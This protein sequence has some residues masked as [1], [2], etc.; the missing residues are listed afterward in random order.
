MKLLK[1]I[2]F[3]YIIKR[4]FPGGGP[5]KKVMEKALGATNQEL[6]KK[7]IPPLQN[8]YQVPLQ[9][10]EAIQTNNQV[11]PKPLKFPEQP[12]K[13]KPAEMQNLIPYKIENE[14][15]N[16][17]LDKIFKKDNIV[18]GY[19][20]NEI[21]NKLKNL[22]EEN[23]E[24][25]K[26][27]IKK[28]IEDAE[29]EILNK[30]AQNIRTFNSIKNSD[31][32]TKID[33]ENEAKKFTNSVTDT[34][35][36]QKFLDIL[37]KNN[38]LKK[39]L[40]LKSSEPNEITDEIKIAFEL[41]RETL[42]KLIDENLDDCKQKFYKENFQDN[43]FEQ[44]VLGYYHKDAQTRWQY[45]DNKKYLMAI[46]K[47]LQTDIQLN[48][49]QLLYIS[50]QLGKI[51]YANVIYKENTETGIVSYNYGENGEVTMA[52]SLL[53][54]KQESGNIDNE[55]FVEIQ[56]NISKETILE[57]L[58]NGNFYVSD[59]KI[60]NQKYVKIFIPHGINSHLCISID[61]KDNRL[62]L[63]YLTSS[64][65][66]S[67]IDTVIAEHQLKNSEKTQNL[68]VLSNFCIEKKEN[69]NDIDVYKQF[70]LNEEIKKKLIKLIEANLEISLNSPV[71]T[72]PIM[73]LENFQ[74][75][76]LKRIEE[77][78][79]FIANNLDD[80]ES[81]FLNEKSRNK[82]EHRN[83]KMFLDI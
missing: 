37:Y 61:Y 59:I 57:C 34:N 8:N 79:L 56:P 50:K 20:R 38:H 41:V 23:S 68:N 77:E 76:L 26:Q 27:N 9:V 72:V 83:L 35:E 39:I 75:I 51:K 22:C 74:Q 78:L 21:E 14:E 24:N 52:A 32:E 60:N 42:I 28:W 64:K 62:I 13:A 66:K 16:A 29:I 33:I 73:T 49:K 18:L 40:S 2:K 30:H 67:K 15:L 47:C 17:L 5:G 54:N 31:K 58:N 46:K 44:K 65:S 19:T 11:N 25:C 7:V 3:N 4:F 53:L 80:Y 70:V 63:A 48:E 43:S 82:D 81:F 10:Q 1:E 6:A 36:S 69:M 12:I 71:I 45:E 55:M